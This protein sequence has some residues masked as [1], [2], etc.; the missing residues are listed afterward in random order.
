LN[1]SS[2]LYSFI[3]ERIQS[4]LECIWLSGFVTDDLRN[5]SSDFYAPP[6]LFVGQI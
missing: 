5:D 1:F 4:C 3:D 6:D 2:A